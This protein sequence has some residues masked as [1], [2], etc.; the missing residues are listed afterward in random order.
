MPTLMTADTPQA[1][2]PDPARPA[3]PKIDSRELLGGGRELVIVHAGQEYRLRRTS[4]NK[5]ILTK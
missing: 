2:L 5:L 1:A 4:Q 3:L